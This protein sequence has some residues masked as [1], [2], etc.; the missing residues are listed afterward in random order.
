M[1]REFN[2]TTYSL[3]YLYYFYLPYQLGQHYTY[4]LRRSLGTPTLYNLSKWQ[5][6]YWG[7]ERF[8]KFWLEASNNQYSK[9]RGIYICSGR[10]MKHKSFMKE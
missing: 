10:V 7:N 6:E 4:F 5:F 3:L 9:M 1:I 8:M 2:I